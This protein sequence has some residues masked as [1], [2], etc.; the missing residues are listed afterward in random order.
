MQ[1]RVYEAQ[2]VQFPSSV[3]WLST[4]GVGDY[5]ENVGLP[6]GLLANCLNIGSLTG[7]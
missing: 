6:V 2:F 7:E 3:L 5:E 1:L 4:S